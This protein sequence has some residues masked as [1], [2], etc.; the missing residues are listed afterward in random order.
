MPTKL[1]ECCLKT[2]RVLGSKN[3]KDFFTIAPGK[4]KESVTVLCNFSASGKS[5][6]PMIVFP[7][8]RLPR[9]IVES[10]PPDYFIGRSDSGWMIA[11]TFYI[12]SQL[13]LSLAYKKQHPIS[14][15]A[16]SRWT[17]VICQ[18]RTQ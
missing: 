2:G 6:P 15:S 17:K 8:Q 4:E 9:D 1:E 16:V 3:Y 14:S 5:V 11:P 10:I 13:F 18:F 7:Y 12:C